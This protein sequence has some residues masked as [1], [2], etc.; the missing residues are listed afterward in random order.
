[1]K[2]IIALIL[3]IAFASVSYAADSASSLCFYGNPLATPYYVSNFSNTGGFGIINNGGVSAPVFRWQPD[4]RYG[5]VGMGFDI[6]VPMNN[7]FQA[8]I[9]NMVV[10]HIEYCSPMWGANYGLLDHITYGAGL[11]MSNY[12]PVLKG[13]IVLSD[14]QSSLRAYYNHGIYGVEVLGT[15]TR[16]YGARLTEQVL[17]YITLGQSF[18]SDT[19]GVI[20]IR[21]D[22]STK[23]FPQQSGWSVDA[24]APF[25][26]GSNVFAEY[27]RLNNYG[28]GFS[29][30]V[31]AGYDLRL[32]R[33]TFKAEKRYIDYNFI[34][35]YYN[36]E[37][38][39][40][41][42]DIVSYEASSQNKDG[43]K[44]TLNGDILGRA[45]FWAVLEGYNGSN[46]ALKAEASA[47]LTDQY[48]VSAGY[49]QP[50]FVDSRSLDFKE[51]LIVTTRL[52]YKINPFTQVIANA[53]RA[54]DPDQGKVVVTQWYE[55]ALKF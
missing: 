4:F 47:D 40:N 36:E 2:K 37:Y 35:E 9:D 13:G 3:L 8:G 14:Q 19:D 12:S 52:G 27:A 20:Q 49:Y 51:G 7:G 28:G 38:E 16:V 15:W 42:V 41:P 34:P 48:F 32:A 25:F 46:S 23:I 33:L 21:P 30:G 44:F 45:K 1:M 31:A 29:A 6:N 10:R 55:V 53:K 22:G 17:P 18:V 54:Y 50:N 39:T 43:Y 11:L 26:L 24:T 5:P